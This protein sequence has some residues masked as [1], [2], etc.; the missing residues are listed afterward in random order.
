MFGPNSYGTPLSDCSFT[1]SPDSTP[2]ATIPISVLDPTIIPAGINLTLSPFI[3]TATFSSLSF[4]NGSFFIQPNSSTI[5]SAGTLIVTAGTRII[6]KNKLSL[7][8]SVVIL[9]LEHSP[10]YSVASG[11]SIV[12]PL[13]DEVGELDTSKVGRLELRANKLSRECEK[14]RMEM[15]GSSEGKGGLQVKVSVDESECELQAAE[16]TSL[17][18]AVLLV[19]IGVPCLIAIAAV[20]QYYLSLISGEVQ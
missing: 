18:G 9:D 2:A 6:V 5:V 11:K 19:V 14:Y 12:V 10:T 7:N 4:S 1:S 13:F 17:V 15:E 3:S 20:S 16:E 8:N